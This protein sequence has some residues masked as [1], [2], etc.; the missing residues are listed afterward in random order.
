VLEREDPAAQGDPTL[1]RPRLA[2]ALH[3]RDFPAACA[4]LARG[5]AAERA[6]VP[7]LEDLSH[8]TVHARE[9]LG[10]D[11]AALLIMQTADLD[12]DGRPEIVTNG[13]GPARDVSIILG[14]DPSLP[15][16]RAVRWD[17][18]AEGVMP[19]PHALTGAPMLLTTQAVGSG[20]RMQ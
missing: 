11:R 7:V 16:W 15:V 17:G 12:G 9:R 10:I 6:W 4:A 14:A 13:L 19:L 1:A 5:P 2:A 18:P 20:F 3:R 8:V